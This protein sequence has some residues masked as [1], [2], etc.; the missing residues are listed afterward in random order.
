[1]QAWKKKK[2]LMRAAKFTTVLEPME[3]EVLGDLT[4]TVSEA[5]IARAQSVRSPKTSRSMG[6]KTVVNLAARMSDC[7]FFQACIGAEAEP[8][9]IVGARRVVR[10]SVVGFAGLS[11]EVE[12]VICRKSELVLVSAT[13]TRP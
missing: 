10:S 8:N 13:S 6:S 11:D 4:D 2:S 7:F 3:R 9:R 1:M 5:I 12:R